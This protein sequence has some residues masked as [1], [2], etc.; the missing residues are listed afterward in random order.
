MLPSRLQHMRVDWDVVVRDVG[1]IGGDVAD[2]SHV[3]S[4]IVDL[5]Y[6][7]AARH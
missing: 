5:V 6:R 7:V 1:P 4:K 2:T 3:R